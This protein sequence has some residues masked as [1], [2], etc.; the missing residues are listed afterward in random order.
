MQD[1][2]IDDQPPI[3]TLTDD[4]RESLRLAIA[5]TPADHPDKARHTAGAWPLHDIGYGIRIGDIAW[6]GFGSAY[7]K[8]EHRANARLIAASPDL[9]EAVIYQLDL[10]QW[11]ESA[12]ADS[13]LFDETLRLRLNTANDYMQAAIA[14]ATGEDTP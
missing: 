5:D 6:I 14:K 12:D 13:P 10:N 11:I 9:L 3:G 8:E 2:F 4:A 1:D 7:S